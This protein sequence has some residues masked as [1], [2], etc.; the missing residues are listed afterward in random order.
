MPNTH[1]L[2]RKHVDRLVDQVA[3][4]DLDTV[5]QLLTLLVKEDIAP[6][7]AREICEMIEQRL[8]MRAAL[9]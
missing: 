4:A 5:Y 6:K 8:G 7:A 2:L 1:Q 9:R 3:D